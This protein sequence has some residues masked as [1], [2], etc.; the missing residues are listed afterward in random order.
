MHVRGLNGATIQGYYDAHGGP[1]AYLGT[2]VPGIPNFYLLAGEFIM[3]MLSS[4]CCLMSQ[5]QDQIQE[6][7]HQRCSW[8]K[9]K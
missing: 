9:F 7:Q 3:D 1:T 6:R 5:S 8:K 2:A 4:I